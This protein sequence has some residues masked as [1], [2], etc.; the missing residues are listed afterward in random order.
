[1]ISKTITCAALALIAGGAFAQFPGS[2]Q[3]NSDYVPTLLFNPDVQKDMH[4]SPALV[5]KEQS[6][7][8]EQAMAML[9]LVMNKQGKGSGA[10]GASPFGQGADTKK[11]LDAVHAMMAKVVEPL[12]ASQRTRF[13]ELT[14][15][16]IGPTALLQPKIEKQL[17]LTSAQQEKLSTLITTSSERIRASI[18]GPGTSGI[19]P[20]MLTQM[21]P[22]QAQARAA[23]ERKLPSILTSAQLAKWKALQGKPLPSVTDN[24]KMVSGLLGGFGGQH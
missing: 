14:L 6:I 16:Y 22:A 13:H 3:P 5:K 15:Q 17:G 9:P 18:R 23:E 4:M 11:V 7:F 8:M 12:S 21:G 24:N 2:D 20:N 10:A 19:N 1:M